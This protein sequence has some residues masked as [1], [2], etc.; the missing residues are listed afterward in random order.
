MLPLF[1]MMLQAQNGT[2]MDAMARQFGLAQEQAAKAMAAA[3][4]G[5]S[6]LWRAAATPRESMLFIE[7][8][9]KLRDHHAGG[10][11]GRP[12]GLQPQGYR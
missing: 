6:P 8:S 11:R 12:A 4:G 2:A 1:D 5:S 9:L 7:D 10:Q 3:G